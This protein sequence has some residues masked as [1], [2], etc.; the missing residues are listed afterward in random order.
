MKRSERYHRDAR[1]QFAY[2]TLCIT[3]V[4]AIIVWLPFNV[5]SFSAIAGVIVGYLIYKSGRFMIECGHMRRL[6]KQSETAEINR[7]IRPRL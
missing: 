5:I 4:I 7:A 2:A 1:R 3:A 6:A